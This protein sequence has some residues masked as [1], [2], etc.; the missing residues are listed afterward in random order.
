MSKTLEGKTILV[1]GAARRVGRLLA[2]A[3][4]GAGA[5]VIIHHGHSLEEALLVQ[6]EIAS[7]GRRAWVL[8]A[9]LSNADEISALKVVS[10]FAKKHNILGFKMGLMGSRVLTGEET[11]SLANTPAK[12]TSIGKLMYLLN[13]HTSHLVR[14]LDAIAKKGVTNS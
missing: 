9:D 2:L 7:L 13:Y 12:E 10:D 1:T 3:C 4:A 8:P 6:K 14:T 5:D 11:L